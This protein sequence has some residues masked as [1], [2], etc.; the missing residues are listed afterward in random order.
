[1]AESKDRKSAHDLLRVAF[2]RRTL[3]IFAALVVAFAILAAAHGVP[4]EYTGVTKFERQTDDAAK[5]GGGSGD[6]FGAAKKKLSLGR[7]VA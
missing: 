7:R 4:L 3:F 6:A 5:M 1:M 2:R